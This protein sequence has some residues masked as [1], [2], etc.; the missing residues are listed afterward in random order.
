MSGTNL[1][2]VGDFKLIDR[3]WLGIPATDKSFDTLDFIMVKVCSAQLLSVMFRRFV[4]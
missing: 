1:R 4:L 2:G 3:E